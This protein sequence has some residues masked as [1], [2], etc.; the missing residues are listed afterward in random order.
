MVATNS[1]LSRTLVRL[2]RCYLAAAA[3]LIGIGLLPGCT[4]TPGD[5][6]GTVKYKGKP[7]ASGSVVF[8]VEGHPPVTAAIDEQG[9]YTAKG[10]PVGAAS[11]AVSSPD[12][13]IQAA[14]GGGKGA[15]EMTAEDL[16]ERQQK[17][18]P[19]SQAQPKIDPAKWF[20]IPDEVSDP[21]RSNLKFDIHPGANT[22][23]I[24][25]K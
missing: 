17:G 1:R 20:P 3:A 13:R 25:L 4:A 24:E 12:P 14:R 11:I 9:H 10:V 15:G 6:T 16:K 8:V 23:D 18:P 21:R 5:V 7:L 2:N 22:F 19:D